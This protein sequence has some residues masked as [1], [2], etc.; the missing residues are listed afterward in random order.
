MVREERTVRVHEFCWCVFMQLCGGL[1]N[2]AEK[3]AYLGQTSKWAEG[4]RKSHPKHQDAGRMASFAALD[5]S[6]IGLASAGG[7]PPTRDFPNRGPC[8]SSSQGKQSSLCCGILKMTA[9]TLRT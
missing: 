1:E 8:P 4:N 7:S 3:R 9:V 5:L 6:L 2:I